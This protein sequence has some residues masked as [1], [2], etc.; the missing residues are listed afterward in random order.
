MSSGEVSRG[1]IYVKLSFEG[2]WLKLEKINLDSIEGEGLGS[3]VGFLCEPWIRDIESDVD[4]FHM[5]ES[6]GVLDVDAEV[7]EKILKE[8]SNKYLISLGTFRK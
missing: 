1:Y 2:G 3:E 5:S 8:E 7:F 4:Q 6:C